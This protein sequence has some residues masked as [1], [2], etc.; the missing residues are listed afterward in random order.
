MARVLKKVM[1]VV[2]SACGDGREIYDTYSDI[3]ILIQGYRNR[4]HNARLRLPLFIQM[5]N[6]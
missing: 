4:Q 6:K 3:P 1:V 2:G 5:R